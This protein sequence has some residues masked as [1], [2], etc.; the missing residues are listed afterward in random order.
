MLIL[1]FFTAGIKEIINLPLTIELENSIKPETPVSQRIKS[2]KELGDNVLI[3]QLEDVFII[4]NK[5]KI[6]YFIK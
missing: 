5:K 3:N 1:L 6:E 4:K 2:L